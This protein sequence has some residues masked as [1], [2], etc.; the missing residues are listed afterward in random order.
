[1]GNGFL[2]DFDEVPGIGD[3]D[4]LMGEMLRGEEEASRQEE[5]ESSGKDEVLSD[6][7]DEMPDDEVDVPTDYDPQDLDFE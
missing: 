1:M 2:D 4:G 5:S 7:M 6:L 3:G